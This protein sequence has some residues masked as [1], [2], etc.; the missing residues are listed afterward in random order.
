[1][2][3]NEGYLLFPLKTFNNLYSTRSKKRFGSTTLL[4]RP[5]AANPHPILMS[6][7]V[8][9]FFK[10]KNLLRIMSCILWVEELI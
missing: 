7:V 6:Y 2:V 3:K 1:M 10:I 9:Q 4:I 5:T 8:Q